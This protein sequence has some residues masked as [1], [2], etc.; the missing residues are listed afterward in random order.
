MQKIIAFFQIGIPKFYKIVVAALFWVILFFLAF[1]CIFSTCFMDANEITY[2][3]S[4][5]VWA[6]FCAVAVVILL[7][8]SVKLFRPFR[9]WL[10]GLEQNDV[11]FFRSRRILLGILFVLALIWVLATQYNA[12]ADQMNVQ[13]AVH[14]IWLEIYTPFEEGGYLS[15]YHNQLGLIWLSYLFSTVFGCYNFVAFQVMNV[16][17]LVLFY[18]EL[19]EMGR[20]FGWRRSVQLLTIVV[21]ILFFPLIMYCS[22]VYGNIMGLAFSAL[23]IRLEIVYFQKHQVRYALCSGGAVLLALLFKSNYLVFFVGMVIY[24]FVEIISQKKVKLLLLPLFFVVVFFIQSWT[25][26]MLG[27]Q[28][29]GEKLDQGAS[30]WSWIAMGLQQEGPLSPGWYN[31]YNQDS[32]AESG[33]NTE[34]QTEMAKENIQQSLKYYW[35]H[36]GEAVRFFT[37]KTASQWNNPSFQ[38]FWLMQ[39][40]ESPNFV[41]SE[42]A[43]NFTNARNTYRGTLLLNLLQFVILVGALIYCLLYWK[44]LHYIRSLILPMIFIGGFLF[45]LFWEAKGQY[46]LSYFV[47]L[48]PCAAAGYSLLTNKLLLLCGKKYRTSFPKRLKKNWKSMLSFA[49]LS[50]MM[51]VVIA[52]CCSGD[53]ASY[54]TE[55]TEAYVQYVETVSEASS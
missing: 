31:F 36:K 39:H 47:L 41:M 16:F 18:R 42:W 17:G 55:D 44:H 43:E 38:C 40:H 22:F 1:L 51:V 6:N 33:Y 48:I 5:S 9:E 32:Y 2:F 12:I 23:A 7:M 54:L 15:T 10:N 20:W 46:T 37:Q 28:V 52:V 35:E 19:S 8:F 45:H 53:K 21:G 14:N 4:D 24:A 11:R 26:V 13:D 27:E 30:S 25:P 49:V 3:S 50:V 29:S 34:V